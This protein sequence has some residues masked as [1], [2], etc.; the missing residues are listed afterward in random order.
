MVPIKTN[1][2]GRALRRR[3]DVVSPNTGAMAS[4]RI[5]QISGHLAGDPDPSRV[6]DLVVIITGA[7]QG[8]NIR[9]PLITAS[10]EAYGAVATGIGR[11]AAILLTRKG[12]KVAVNDLDETKAQGVVQEI[13]D[14]GYEAE[15]Y[16]GDALDESFPTQLVAAVLRKWGKVN[17]IINNAG[18]CTRGE[19]NAHSL[20]YADGSQGS[21]MTAPSTK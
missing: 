14:A 7:A 21:V 4:K 6:D 10:N 15:C 1:I 20:L 11:S 3:C 19:A 9:N 12:A 8:T 16:P 2:S 13:R 17:C 5:D 18:M